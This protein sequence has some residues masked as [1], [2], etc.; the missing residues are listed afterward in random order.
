[1]STTSTTPP[2]GASGRPLS[3]APTRRHAS[4]GHSLRAPPLVRSGRSWDTAWFASEP[5]LQPPPPGYNGKFRHSRVLPQKPT[6][7]ETRLTGKLPQRPYSVRYAAWGPL[8][9][10]ARVPLVRAVG[11]GPQL[12]PLLAE[13]ERPV[14]SARRRV[15]II[16]YCED[17]SSI[18]S[19]ATRYYIATS[20]CVRTHQHC[21]GDCSTSILDT[22]GLSY[23]A[24]PT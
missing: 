6:K 3:F 12:G 22:P 10:R 23:L 8:A 9:L 4:A 15:A 20:L 21:V 2:V 13:A 19:N 17:N 1:M 18:A 11:S 7:W 16:R 14:H 5:Q 24:S